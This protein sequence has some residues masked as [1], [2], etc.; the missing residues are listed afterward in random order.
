MISA[1]GNLFPNLSRAAGRRRAAGKIG[2]SRVER[3]GRDLTGL[4]SYLHN[5]IGWHGT[6]A[7][8]AGCVCARFGTAMDSCVSERAVR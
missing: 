3:F 8:A 1:V 7:K 5:R 4:T 6:C 2:P